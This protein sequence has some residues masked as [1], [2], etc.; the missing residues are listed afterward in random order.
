[1]LR[2]FFVLVIFGGGFYSGVQ[3]AEHQYVKDPGKLAELM[4]KSV[5]E[6]A[7][8]QLDKAKKILEK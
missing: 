4:K 8:K 3:F 7:T 2:L 1:M 5:K 6:T